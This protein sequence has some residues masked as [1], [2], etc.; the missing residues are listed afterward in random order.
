[1]DFI[2]TS[3]VHNLL[4]APSHAGIV[5]HKE[6]FDEEIMRNTFEAAGLTAFKF[7]HACTSAVHGKDMDIFL[8]QGIRQATV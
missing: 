3:H 4:S 1:M 5:A 7:E 6:G 8:A 2:K